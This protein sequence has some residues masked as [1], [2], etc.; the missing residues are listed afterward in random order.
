MTEWSRVFN[1]DENE[2]E[3]EYLHR[4]I[5][6][7]IEQISKRDKKAHSLINTHARTIHTITGR[8]TLTNAVGN[9][10]MSLYLNTQ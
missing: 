1:C 5:D 4:M 6:K 7:A 10:K 9:L 3:G 2:M 8:L